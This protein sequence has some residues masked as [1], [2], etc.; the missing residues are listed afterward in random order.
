MIHK[1]S[2]FVSIIIVLISI[3]ACI[4]VDSS[5]EDPSLPFTVTSREPHAVL[6]KHL[7]FSQR[8]LVQMEEGKTVVKIFNTKE[9]ENEIEAFGVVRLNIPKELFAEHF[10]D[11]E[12]FTESDVIKAVGRFS[13]PPR[14]GDIQ[15]LTLDTTDLKSLKKCRPGSC[16]VKIDTVMMERF[17]QDV[18]W[19]APDY[20]ERATALMRQFLLDYVKAYQEEGYAAMGEYHDQDQPLLIANAFQNLLQN[21]AFL[22]HYAPELYTYLKDY[23]KGRLSNAEN[24]F[25]W[26]VE[27]FG[28]KPVINLFHATIYTR[29]H[30]DSNDVFIT[31]NRIYASHYF[32]TSLS[33]TAFIDGVGGEGEPDSYL[34]YLNRSRFDMLRGPLKGMIIT[35]ARNRVY[36]GVKEYFG[37][38]KTRLE[39][40]YLVQKSE[41]K[42]NTE[43]SVSQ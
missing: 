36:D 21:S 15:Q 28:F 1:T 29:D 30:E 12:T 19:S 4:Q 3:T 37:K 40:E 31:V 34:M 10:R 2:I 43:F 18:D 6:Q 13:S 27:E 16:K 22:F 25:Y 24:F 41:D 9:V 35:L 11:I 14:L 5:K 32:E 26:T 38:V 23:P 20:K 8:D 17:Q 39:D 33:F 42:N 7:H